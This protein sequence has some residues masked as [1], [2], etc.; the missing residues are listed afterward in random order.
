[1]LSRLDNP[2]WP[3]NE[4]TEEG[5]LAEAFPA[6]QLRHWELPYTRYNGSGSAAR[7]VRLQIISSLKERLSI[8]IDP[9]KE[10]TLEASA[11]ALD[12]PLC[13]IAAVGVTQGKSRQ[14][15]SPSVVQEGWIAVQE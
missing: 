6:A 5:L 10:R 12:S 9:E 2:I 13:A 8:D 14:G 7:D 3:W 11:D 4:T 1:L 15:Q